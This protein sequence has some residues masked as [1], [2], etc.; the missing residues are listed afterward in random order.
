MHLQPQ[1]AQLEIV[2]F[3]CVATLVLQ[4]AKGLT[5]DREGWE[6]GCVTHASKSPGRTYR[7]DHFKGYR[8]PGGNR[9]SPAFKTGKVTQ[10]EEALRLAPHLDQYPTPIPYQM[11][12]ANVLQ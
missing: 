12:P 5:K 6:T 7:P 9:E 11:S 8:N 2:I 3:S 4:H 10:I 1:A